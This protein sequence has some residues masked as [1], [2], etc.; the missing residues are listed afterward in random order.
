VKKLKLVSTI[1]FAV[2]DNRFLSSNSML[3]FALACPWVTVA[4]F[5]RIV[6]EGVADFTCLIEG[7]VS[8]S[9]SSSAMNANRGAAVR[10]MRLL[11]HHMTAENGGNRRRLS[12]DQQKINFDDLKEADRAIEKFNNITYELGSCLKSNALILE[13]AFK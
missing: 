6:A 9:L 2:F 1:L 10:R 5:T 13:E 12:F 4:E 8:V 7:A 11:E 3:L